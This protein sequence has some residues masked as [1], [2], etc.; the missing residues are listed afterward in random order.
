MS[1]TESDFTPVM[2]DVV[3]EAGVTSVAVNVMITNDITLEDDEIFTATIISKEPNVIVDDTRSNADITI[4][5]DDDVSIGFNPTAYM[6]QEGGSVELIIERMGDAEVAVVAT[7]ST[8]DGS[9]TG[10]Y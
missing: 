8:R 1:L 7:V 9:A 10:K 4:L 5:E 6:V 2:G 3:F